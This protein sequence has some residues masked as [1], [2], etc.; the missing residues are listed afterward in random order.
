MNWIQGL[1]LLVL[2]GLA[3]NAWDGFRRLPRPLRLGSRR[4]YRREDGRWYTVWG[5]LVDDPVLEQALQS[6]NAA[7]TGGP[8]TPA[9]QDA[10]P[11][12]APDSAG[13]CTERQ[14]P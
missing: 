3:W 1:R 7:A 12:P 10:E 11:G 2:A 6:S 9:R 13:P 4:Y 5:R 14:H 8:S